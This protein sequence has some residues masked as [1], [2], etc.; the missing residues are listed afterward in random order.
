MATKTM[1]RQIISK[2]GIMSP[3]LIQAF[4]VDMKVAQ[5][6]NDFS[7]VVDADV[8]EGALTTDQPDVMDAEVVTSKPVSEPEPEMDAALQPTS[9]IDD[10]VSIFCP[11]KE[12]TMSSEDCFYCT[13]RDGCP[14]REAS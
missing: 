9:S 1:L 2:W 14:E 12:Q 7:G 13:D 5:G 8:F 11:K 6:L 3:E 10:P 4:D